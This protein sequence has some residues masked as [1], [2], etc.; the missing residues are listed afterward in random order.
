MTSSPPAL[1]DLAIAAITAAGGLAHL[2]PDEML[3]IAAELAARGYSADQVAHAIAAATCEL[4]AA[5][6][7]TPGRVET[8]LS[9]AHMVALRR[10]EGVR[11]LSLTTLQ[12]IYQA[13]TPGADEQA[14]PNDTIH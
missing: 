6:N 4:L 2:P 3:R 12:S 9:T 7:G 8:D 13:T 5:E 14:K 10:P 11:Y 1:Q